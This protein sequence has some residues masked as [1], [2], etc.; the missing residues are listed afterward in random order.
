[1]NEGYIKLH[2]SILG[3]RWYDDVNTFRLFIHLLLKA[4]HAPK[5]WHKVRIERGQVVTGRKKLAKELRLTEQNIRTSLSHLISTKEITI[6]STKRY[7][8]I[9]LINWDKY[10]CL[11]DIPNQDDNEGRNQVIPNLRMLSP[12]QQECTQ[13]Y[14]TMRLH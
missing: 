7:T 3:W 12:Q 4:N 9:N 5:D 13:I 1:M 8:T 2:R 11:T 10:Q 14:H 6:V